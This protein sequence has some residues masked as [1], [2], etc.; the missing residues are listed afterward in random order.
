MIVRV[1]GKIEAV[2]DDS[3]H[4]TMGDFTYELFVPA[5]DVPFLQTKVGQPVTFFT[6][7][8][9]EGNPSFGSLAPRLIGFLRADDRAFFNLFTTVKGIGVRRAL[10]ALTQPVPQI[11][12][13]IMLKD[14]KFLTSLPEIG[15]RTAEQ[16]IAELHGKVN[17]FAIGHAPANVPNAPPRPD[18]GRDAVEALVT[19]GER[20][21]E[22]ESWVDRALRADPGLKDAREVISAVYRLKSG[23]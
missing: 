10:R 16:M 21:P 6:L 20:R 5:A 15:K 1:A 9:I 11:A 7:S 8:Y 17:D 23:G 2:T 22:A 12:N 14:T 13:A 19:L 4:V 3:V 18:A